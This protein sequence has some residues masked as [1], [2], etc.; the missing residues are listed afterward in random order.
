MKTLKQRLQDGEIVFG[1]TV[2]EHLRPSV[3]K[4]FANAGFDFIFVENEHAWFDGSQLADFVL[5]ARDNGLTIVAKIPQLERAETARLLEMGA[6]GIQ[7][8]RTETR[9]QLEH[10]HD[11][12]KF[13]PVGSRASAT[14]FG[15]T[16]YG[17]VPDKRAWYCEANDETMVV[18]HIETRAGAEDIDDILAAEGTDICFVGISDLSLSYGMPGQYDD[19]QFRSVV[20]RIFDATA[21]HNVIRGI[22]GL[23]EESVR[24]WIDQGAQF[25]ECTS[26][27]DLIRSG[28]AQTIEELHRARRVGAHR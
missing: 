25:F 1:A 11:F 15:N 17:K 22:V 9:Q 5:C 28:A 7:L 2:L 3:V 8:P 18:A 13:P 21:R 27:M 4:A 19:P 12:I 26:E 20:Q 10:L 14:G 16:F 6:M 24:Y 23:N